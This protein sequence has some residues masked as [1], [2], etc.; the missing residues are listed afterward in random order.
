MER[1]DINTD[2]NT[3]T[4][5]HWQFINSIYP[6]SIY[7]NSDRDSLLPDCIKGNAPFPKNDLL[8]ITSDLQVAFAEHHSAPSNL[9]TPGD[10][11]VI[12]FVWWESAIPGLIPKAFPGQLLHCPLTLFSYCSLLSLQSSGRTCT[13]LVWGH[14]LL[15]GFFKIMET[16]FKILGHLNQ[17]LT[18][19]DN[20]LNNHFCLQSEIPLLLFHRHRTATVTGN[21]V[22][23]EN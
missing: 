5:G 12:S 1:D 13:A 20:Y 14:F 19:T 8:L 9:D 7:P 22:T 17:H 4:F 6:L 2:L 10:L 15:I 18:C 16:I 11:S 3:L 23:S 21:A